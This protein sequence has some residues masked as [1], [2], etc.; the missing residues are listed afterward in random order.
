MYAR[1]VAY[2]SLFSTITISI[3]R[4]MASYNNGQPTEG[5]AMRMRS[6]QAGAGLQIPLQYNSPVVENYDS[7]H[8]AVDT[9]SHEYNPRGTWAQ[10]YTP[11]LQQKSIL[12]RSAD[13]T[14][15]REEM[16]SPVPPP[17]VTSVISSR[18]SMKQSDD[19]SDTSVEDTHGYKMLLGKERWNLTQ[20]PFIQDDTLDNGRPRSKRINYI[21]GVRGVMA[22]QTLLW[23][24]FRTFAPA[25]VTDTDLDGTFPAPFVTSSPGWMSIIRKVFA[26]ILFDGSIQMTMFI[27]L[28]GRTGLLTYIERRQ[29]INLAGQCFRRPIR[30]IVPV[31][32]TVA[33]ISIL[34]ATNGFKYAPFLAD[35]LKNEA[36]QPPLKF[37]NALEYFNS[38][39]SLLFEPYAERDTRAVNFLPVGQIAWFIEV[40]YQQT[41]VLTVFAFTLPFTV[42]KYKVIGFSVM[43]LL[44]AWVARWS[45]YTVTGLCIAE[46]A[47]VYRSM[48]PDRSSTAT[49]RRDQRRVSLTPVTKNKTANLMQWLVPAGMLF[50][51]LLLRYVWT[52][53]APQYA[54][55]ELLAHGDVGTGGIT[56]GFD[57]VTRAFPRYDTWLVCTGFLILLELSDKM[58]VVLASPLFTY[59]GRLAFSIVLLSGTI[60]ISLGGALHSHLVQNLGW[61]NP[62]KI[63]FVEFLTMVPFCLIGADIW[64]RTVDDLGLKASHVIFEFA[65]N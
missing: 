27:I 18:H 33:L 55:K 6:S 34:T 12:Q 50:A 47:V 62:S 9:P 52:S 46:F 38:L 19:G 63:V 61:T 16:A 43:V 30:I 15:V 40:A 54:N 11:T 60:M 44:S 2:G 1:D 29:A 57:A 22:F 58:Q 24:F 41:Y 17:R 23:I 3:A 25:I 42:F 39:L 59:L 20:E 35:N 36:A 10:S 13:L 56:K 32:L 14:S 21:E 5:G 28:M 8:Y 49:T 48:L 53:I 51:G 37:D 65:R 7:Q 31:A 45:W 64:S 26:P 4:K